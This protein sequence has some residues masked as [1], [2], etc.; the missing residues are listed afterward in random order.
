MQM[1]AQQAAVDALAL[2]WVWPCA[3]LD[4][5]NAIIGWIG[6]FAV[7]ETQMYTVWMHFANKE[8]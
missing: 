4:I 8:S 2:C 6:W 1:S 5:F 3:R 7:Q